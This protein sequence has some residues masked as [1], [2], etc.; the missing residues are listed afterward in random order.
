[1]GYGYTSRSDFLLTDKK[2]KERIIAE[3]EKTSHKH[4]GIKSE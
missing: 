3:T 1:M 4:W 2:D